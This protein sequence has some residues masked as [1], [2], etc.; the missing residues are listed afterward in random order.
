M[1]GLIDSELVVDQAN[2]VVAEYALGEDLKGKKTS[3]GMRL[4]CV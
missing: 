2:L 4:R 1:A 3:R